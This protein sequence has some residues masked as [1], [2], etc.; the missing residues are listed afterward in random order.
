MNQ[1][2]KDYVKIYNKLSPE[3]CDNAVSLL[4]NV[5]WNTHNFYVNGEDRYYSA[6]S[7]GMVSWNQL[8]IQEQ[9]NQA[10]WDCLH[11]YVVQDLNFEWFHGWQQF[12]SIR[13]NRYD[14]NKDMKNHCDHIHD[15][16]DGV[17]KGIPVLSIVGLLNDE[18]E[19]GELIFFDDYALPI[20]KGD[21]VIFPSNF[22]F[23]HRVS[24]ITSG[25]RFSFV[26][27]AW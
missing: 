12:T 8:P 16:F 27:W 3:F 4:H 11:Q 13:F 2:L 5:D 23:P 20:K 1:N 9:L 24:T 17:N 6:D 7:D 14:K 18:F 10:V 26:S 25:S 22:L 21:I 19:G 15:I